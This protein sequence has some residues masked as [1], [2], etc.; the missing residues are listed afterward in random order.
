PAAENGKARGRGIRPAG[1]ARINVPGGPKVRPARIPF[2][3]SRT[4]C[5]YA[6]RVTPSGAPSH[7]GSVLLGVLYAAGLRGHRVSRFRQGLGISTGSSGFSVRRPPRAF[8]RCFI[9]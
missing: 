5:R 4:V 2:G 3:G 6:D 1:F 7:G 9:L 8:A